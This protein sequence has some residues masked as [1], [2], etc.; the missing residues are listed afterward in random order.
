MKSFPRVLPD[1]RDGLLAR[2]LSP[3]PIHRIYDNKPLTD[4]GAQDFRREFHTSFQTNSSGSSLCWQFQQS[5]P[6]LNALDA[7]AQRNGNKLQIE[8]LH[9]CSVLLLQ[10]VHPTHSIDRPAA[11]ALLPLALGLIGTTPNGP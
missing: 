4:V 3:F 9:S 5:L 11:A 6:A 1:A 8:W 10:V 2:F 7:R